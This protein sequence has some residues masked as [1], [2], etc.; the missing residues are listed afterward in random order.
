[1]G[2]LTPS[3]TAT[4]DNS[5]DPEVD[6]YKRY[7]TN[8][9]IQQETNNDIPDLSVTVSV[10]QRMRPIPP[11]LD[12]PNQ[13]TKRATEGG[14]DKIQDWVRRRTEPNGAKVLEVIDL[15]DD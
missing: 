14:D 13:P 4:R 1:M 9:S 2:V 6:L 12:L 3:V 5:V 7:P 15:T 8:T 11:L 10:E